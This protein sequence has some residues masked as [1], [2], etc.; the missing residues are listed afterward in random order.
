MVCAANKKGIRLVI[1]TPSCMNVT[2]SVN[3]FMFS[4]SKDGGP[5]SHKPTVVIK[6]NRRG[7]AAPYAFGE[8][9]DSWARCQT[10]TGGETNRNEADIVE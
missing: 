1:K 2:H 4:L 3:A 9:F 10:F 6:Q 5:P 8:K 7:A